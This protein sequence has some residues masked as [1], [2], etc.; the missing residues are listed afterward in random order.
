MG[1]DY[2]GWHKDNEKSSERVIASLS[3]GVPRKFRIRLDN[4]TEDL[5]LE[6]GSL[7][8]FDGYVEHTLPRMQKVNQPRINLTFRTIK[9]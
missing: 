9:T 5:W 7:L 6:N 1:L 2:M 4:E 8:V 3:L